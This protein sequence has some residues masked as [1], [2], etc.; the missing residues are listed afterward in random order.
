MSNVPFSSI[1]K[2]LLDSLSNTKEVIKTLKT[3]VSTRSMFEPQDHV[4]K[5][6]AESRI[7]PDVT[8]YKETIQAVMRAVIVMKAIID[9]KC[10]VRLSLLK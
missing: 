1:D 6:T 10:I 7:S 3:L 9:V 8:G 4:L 5:P 2:L